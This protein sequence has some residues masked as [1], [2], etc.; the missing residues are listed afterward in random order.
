VSAQEEVD[1][2]GYK[3]VSTHRAGARV[4]ITA[5]GVKITTLGSN[6]S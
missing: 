4:H 1:L 5:A 6:P 3:L 2:R